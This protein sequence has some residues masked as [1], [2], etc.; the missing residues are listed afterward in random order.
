MK[1]YRFT[2]RERDEESG[3]SYHGKRYYVPGLTR[4]ASCDPAGITGG[5]DLYIYVRDNPL[6]LTDLSG[7]QPENLPQDAQ[8]NYLVPGETI[9]IHVDM[10]PL[11]ELDRQK[12]AGLSHYDSRAEVERQLRFQ[13]RSNTS[14]YSW[15]TGPPEPDWDAMGIPELAEEA[16]A[17]AEAKWDEYVTKEYQ[18]RRRVKERELAKQQNLTNSYANLGKIIGGG[19]IVGVAAVGGAAA[20]GVGAGLK[21]RAAFYLGKELLNPGAKVLAA[22]VAYGVAAP[23]GAPDLLGPGDDIGRL[24]RAGISRAT[25]EGAEAFI[26]TERIVAGYDLIG[27]AA[28]VGDNYRM[29]ITGWYERTGESQGLLSLLGALKSEAAASGASRLEIIGGMV[30]NKILKRMTPEFAARFGF[31]FERINETWF[32]LSGPVQ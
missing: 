16:R 26:G 6:R 19:T 7:M 17:E 27:E 31:E 18:R 1:R 13:M 22:T 29:V 32:R 9:R 23:P 30:E 25:S 20:V 10:P 15:L 12:R 5:V 3:L 21:G 24:A 14:D 2:G 28:R 8:G 4:W 11:D